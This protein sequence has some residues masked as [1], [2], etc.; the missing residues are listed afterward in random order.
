MRILAVVLTLG[1]A[2]SAGPMELNWPE[3]RR[4][5]GLAWSADGSGLFVFTIVNNVPVVERRDLTNWESR[6]QTEVLEAPFGDVTSLV[7]SPDRSELVVVGKDSFSILSCATGELRATL[8]PQGD[9]Q[10]DFI[11]AAPRPDGTVVVLAREWTGFP[12][13]LQLYVGDP[14]KGLRGR[15]LLGSSDIGIPT[16]TAV[17]SPQ[18]RYLA[19]TAGTQEEPA[20]V[21][22]SVRIRDL[23]SGSERVFDLRKLLPEV[24]WQNARAFI[25]AVALRPDGKEV[26]AGLFLK[27]SG[28]P[29]MLRL[30]V[31][32]GELIEPL[33]L[34]AENET[35]VRYL[36]YS[37]DGGRLAIS[38][39]PIDPV[40]GNAELD[41][42]RIAPGGSIV[43]TIQR[44]K[45]AAFSFLA[46]SPDGRMLAGLRYAGV[47]LWDLCPETPELPVPGWSFSFSSGG[48]YIPTGPEEWRVQL[49]ASGK[50]LIARQVVDE[51]EDFGPF[52]LSPEENEELWKLILALDIPCRSSSRRS[53]IPDEALMSFAL[54]GPDR[55]Y[56]VKLWEGDARRY[57]EISAFLKELSALIERYTGEEPGL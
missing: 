35:G 7:L 21:F 30:D 4:P 49:D 9:V 20:A 56:T 28:H 44:G 6:W 54:T 14:S 5:C 36:T 42:V 45:T 3:P 23:T 46:F 40:T 12:P 15:E 52:H 55:T 32:T 16:P 8:E 31:D 19:Y 26:A 24:S 34:A 39:V 37:P 47:A 1:L 18:A 43:E 50:L 11:A 51:V 27:D 48:A 57:P 41:I 2:A 13:A 10:R 25:S 17:F 29:L 53:G 22:W 38:I 33:L